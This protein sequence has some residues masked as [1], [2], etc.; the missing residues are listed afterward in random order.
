MKNTVENCN[1][2]GYNN[3]AVNFDGIKDVSITD[4]IKNA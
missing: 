4:T 1:I 2:T 3:F